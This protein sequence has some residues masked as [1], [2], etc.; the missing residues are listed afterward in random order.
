M[1]AAATGGAL[2]HLPGGQ[3]SKGASTL[4]VDVVG[5]SG[6]AQAGSAIGY[7]NTELERI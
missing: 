3:R 2:F 7:L 4:G 1:P 6:A 5:M